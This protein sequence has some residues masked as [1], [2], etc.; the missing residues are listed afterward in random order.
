M[1]HSFWEFLSFAPLWLRL[2]DSVG[3]GCSVHP[4]EVGPSVGPG[5]SWHRVL[6]MADRG[7]LFVGV[8]PLQGLPLLFFLMAEP[9]D[10]GSVSAT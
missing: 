2:W 10:C 4:P 7:A 3:G 8:L 9:L 5:G 1:R 6:A